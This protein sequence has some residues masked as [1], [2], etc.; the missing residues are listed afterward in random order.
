MDK[1]KIAFLN[2]V[3]ALR[4]AQQYTA[5]CNTTSTDRELRALEKKFDKRMELFATLGEDKFYN[6]VSQMRDAQQKYRAHHGKKDGMRAFLTELAVDHLI[7][8]LQRQV[9]LQVTQGDLFE[10]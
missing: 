9:A 3:T 5:G 7:I 6:A 10:K 8:T 1:T 4:R 2:E